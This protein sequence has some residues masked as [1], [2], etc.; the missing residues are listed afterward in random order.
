MTSTLISSL[1]QISRLESSIA[2]IPSSL[3]RLDSDVRSKAQD[4]KNL[5]YVHQM[6]IAYV[7]LLSCFFS[8]SN[9]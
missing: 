3:S 2:G 1:Q 9:I 7:I 5:N 8:I 4:F 6:P